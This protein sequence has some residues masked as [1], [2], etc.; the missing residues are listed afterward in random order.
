MSIYLGADEAFFKGLK[1]KISID[2][3]SVCQGNFF[4]YKFFFKKKGFWSLWIERS[5]S[6]I[7]ESSR[8]G[9]QTTMSL[10]E[11]MGFFLT[12]LLS[13]MINSPRK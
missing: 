6:Q 3:G 8:A 1:T 13:S 7:I 5:F 11:T 12:N 4:P 2:K 10:S 9:E